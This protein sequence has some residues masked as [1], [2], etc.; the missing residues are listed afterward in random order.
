MENS[1]DPI[2]MLDRACRVLY[3][4][5]ASLTVLNALGRQPPWTQETL[6]G[7]S[8]PGILEP[9]RQRERCD[10]GIRPASDR[11]GTGVRVEERIATL[12]GARIHLSIR[13]PLRDAAGQI[14]GLIGIAHD[15]TEQKQGEVERFARLE[16]QRDTLVREV[17]HR[18]KNRWQGVTGLLRNRIA[19]TSGIGQ[20]SG[21]SDRADS[22]HRPRLRL[23]E[24]P[25]RGRSATE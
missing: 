7:K 6:V 13:S 2:F 1:P 5:P 18:I 15:I 8:A 10:V 20:G 16:R 21:R 4:N 19:L 3:V 25:H 23:A 17:H 14:V 24:P 9:F 22:C 11:I 12:D